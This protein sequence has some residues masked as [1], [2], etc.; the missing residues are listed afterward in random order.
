MITRSRNVDKAAK[1]AQSKQKST[2]FTLNEGDDPIVLGNER[3]LLDI[4]VQC[5]DIQDG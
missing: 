3:A 4:G 2:T 1:K 5:V